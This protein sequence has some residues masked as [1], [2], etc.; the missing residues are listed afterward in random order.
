VPNGE[1]LLWRISRDGEKPSYLFGTVHLSDERVTVLPRVVSEALG[2]AKQVA[3]EVADVSPK[4][5]FAAIG[6]MQ[7]RVVF[8][9]GRS[10]LT[11]LDKAELEGVHAALATVGF[12]PA[13]QNVLRPWFVS[14]MFSVTTCERKR[15][16]AGLQP[17]D[18]QIGARARERG[19]PV[20]SL[21]TLEGQL[22]AMASIPEPDQISLLKATLRTRESMADAV[23]SMLQRYLSREMTKVLPM[24]AE[25]MHA[26]G[27]DPGAAKSLR[28]ALLTNRNPRMRDAALPILAKGEAFI[29]VGALHLIGDDGLV[30]LLRKAGYHVTPVL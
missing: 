30:A 26:A 15:L 21:E 11:M 8:R 19:I 27:F 25:L 7:D 29:A 23:E 12:P 4:A 13:V 18:M 1:A 28:R 10:L 22:A 6:A 20:Y 14:M 2:S 5:L 16:Q 17:L 9:D 24:Q 3:L